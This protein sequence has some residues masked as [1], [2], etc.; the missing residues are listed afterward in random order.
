MGVQ[1]GRELNPGNFV[2]LPHFL[3]EEGKRKDVCTADKP[4]GTENVE[5]IKDAVDIDSGCGRCLGD[6]R[7]SLALSVVTYGGT[8]W[9]SRG[10]RE[11]LTCNILDGS[12]KRT[13]RVDCP[14]FTV[15]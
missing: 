3:G 15:D 14:P 6:A 7:P 1:L 8:R 5:D 12:G 10:G 9:E 13:R 2:T 11:E 4:A